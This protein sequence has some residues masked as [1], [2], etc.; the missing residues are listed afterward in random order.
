V[1]AAAT[2]LPESR[3]PSIFDTVTVGLRRTSAAF[4]SSIF[5]ESNTVDGAA[6]DSLI[7]L[8]CLGNLA[9]DCFDVGLPADERA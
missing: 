7:V 3:F 6:E 8:L 2:R 1:A 4:A 9:F 5:L